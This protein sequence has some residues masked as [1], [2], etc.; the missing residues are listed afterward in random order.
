MGATRA[1]KSLRIFLITGLLSVCWLSSFYLQQLHATASSKTIDISATRKH[2]IEK[3]RKVLRTGEYEGYDLIIISSTS[4][5]EAE[6]QQTM[7]ETLFAG[8]S[9]RE[10]RKPIL[11]S[12]VDSTE[13][14]QLIGSV[15][16]WL[17]AEEMMREKYP[18]L[19]AG[20]KDLISY[21]K[22]NKLKAAAFHDGGKGERCSPLTQSLGNSR[23]SQ[24]LVGTIKNAEGKSIE[25]DILSSVI[26]QCAS[27]ASTNQGTHFDTFWTSQIAF[28]SHFHDKLIRSNFALDKFIVGFSKDDLNPNN[29]I[30]FG[31][32]A[33][34]AQGRMTAFFGNK[35]FASRQGSEY[36]LNREKINR[37]LLAK[38]DQVAYDFGSFAISLELWELMLDYWKRKCAFDSSNRKLKIKRDIDPHFIQPFIR[39]LYGLHDLADQKTVRKI[40]PSPES[41]LSEEKLKAARI[42]FDHFLKTSMPEAHAY[43]WED[44]QQETDEKKKAE[45]ASYLEEVMEF[46][47]LNHHQPLFSDLAKV[48]GYIDLG[49]DTQWFRYRRPI[50]IMNEKFAMLTDLIGQKME[51]LLDGTVQIIKADDASWQRSVEGRLMRGISDHSIAAFSVEGHPVSLSLEEIKNGK[52]IGGVYVKNSIIQ[53]SDLTKGSLVVDSVINNSVGKIVAR[54]SYV[55]SSISPSLKA[56]T[57]IIHQVIDTRPVEARREVV[58][59]VFKT[60]LSP[61][62]HGR[63]RAPIGY[64]PKGMA[65]YKVSKKEEGTLTKELEP[66]LKEFIRKLPYSIGEAKEYSDKTAR[67]EDGRFTFEEI[68]DIEPLKISDDQFRELRMQEAKHAVRSSRRA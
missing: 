68:R 28:G 29:L 36:V 38:G 66:T 22:A 40:F 64:D 43:I 42:D 8:A 32:A 27:F 47:L 63:M 11:L 26:L 59:D 13:A 44:V 35:R 56:R 45:A 2:N 58:S 41:L 1:K 39:F 12:V 24:K 14:G 19:L 23:G 17:K 33:L 53:N 50:D 54:Q 31:T 20:S 4:K 25:L 34:N 15:Y 21:I 57:G 55:E 60:K 37:E 49:N 46:Y 6:F 62:Y 51:I 5:E 67:T 9:N 61:P 3:T 48:F 10:G 16:T 65:I 18:Q 30:D 52:M 7:L